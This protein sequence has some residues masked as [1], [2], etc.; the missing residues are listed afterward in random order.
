MTSHRGH[1]PVQSTGKHY[2]L[3]TG[4]NYIQFCK[5][6]SGGT[7]RFHAKINRRIGNW[8]IIILKY[9][10]LEKVYLENHER[11]FKI[12]CIPVDKEYIRT[13]VELDHEPDPEPFKG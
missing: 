1:S 3:H 13:Y 2:Y 7:G 10:F 6:R 11:I 12:I 5:S 9:I 4:T 8:I